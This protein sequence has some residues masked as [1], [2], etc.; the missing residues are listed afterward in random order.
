MLV[1]PIKKII[2]ILIIPLSLILAGLFLFP[3]HESSLIFNQSNNEVEPGQKVDYFTGQDFPEFN[4]RPVNLLFFGDL[5]LDRHIK[6]KLQGHSVSDLIDKA[7]STRQILATPDLISANL[8]GA[9]TNDGLH[10][11]PENVY[12][13][14]F[15]PERIIELQALGFNFFNLANNHFT[16]QGQQGVQ[17]TRE[18]L[19]GIAIN[20]SGSPDAVVDPY[21][22][23]IV[24]LSGRKFAFIGLSMVYHDF[25][26]N[27]AQELVTQAQDQAEMVVINIHWGTEYEHQFNKKQ[28]LVGHALIDAGADLI[29]GH[30]PHVV[31]GVEIYNNRPI[32]YSLGNFI[33]DQ[34]F[35]PDTQ[36]GLAISCQITPREMEFTLIPI[37][38]KASVVS[39]LE[40]IGKS[41]FFNKFTVWSRLDEKG[42]TSL[43]KGIIKLKL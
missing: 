26:L 32:F 15:S 23:Q 36:E 43:N 11:L 40:A 6:E 9:V 31:Q 20:Y 3:H 38:S 24:E 37:Q 39:P 42:K 5:M 14:A 2:I 16:D 21:S 19:T 4:I 10:Y 25:D 41:E 1:D 33:F 12:D 17:E 7:T 29:I 34:Y 30:H 18:N 8:E 35:S 27:A 28:Q 13:F 22:L